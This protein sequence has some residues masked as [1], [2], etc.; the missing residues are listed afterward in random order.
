MVRHRDLWRQFSHLSLGDLAMAVTDPLTTFAV[1]HLPDASLNLQAVGILMPLVELLGAPLFMLLH[2]ANALAPNPR[3]RRA[4]L[5]F[6]VVATTVLGCA[7]Y[8]LSRHTAFAWLARH[9]FGVE[10]SVGESARAALALLVLSPV[11]MGFRRY[12]QGLLVA[13]GH[14]R[15]VAEAA[16]VRI[17]TVGAALTIGVLLHAEGATLAALTY[18]GALT[19]MDRWRSP[20]GPPR[21]AWSASSPA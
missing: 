11:A 7:F 9:V 16:L 14:S 6:V 3:A 10:P 19:T 18:L 12:F 21:S 13:F 1:A 17:A 5:S 20:C 8:A 15:A 4:L 2:A